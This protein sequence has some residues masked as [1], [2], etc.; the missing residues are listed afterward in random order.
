MAVD[1][2]SPAQAAYCRKWLMFAALCWAFLGCFQGLAIGG[3]EN[4]KMG[5]AAYHLLRHFS[6]LMLGAAFVF[7][8]LVLSEKKMK[9][10]FYCMQIAPFSNFVS[11]MIVAIT[12][13]PNPL[14][15][16]SPE[17]VLLIFQDGP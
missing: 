15:E 13:C 7:P 10:A 2:A 11:Y 9:V 3:L 6:E 4:K 17:L 16:N 1:Q 14:F 5:K 12:N 8:Y